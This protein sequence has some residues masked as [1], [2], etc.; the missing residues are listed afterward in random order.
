MPQSERLRVLFCDHLNLARGKYLPGG[1]YADGASTFCRSTFGVQFDKDLLPSPGSMMMEGLPDME[2]RYLGADIRQGW[3]DGEKVVVADL[4]DLEGQPLGTCGRQA[5]K[6][7]IADWQARGLEPMVGIELEATAMQFSDTGRLEPYDNPGGF[8]YGTGPFTDPA[9]VTDAIWH[10]AEEAGF[11]L[12]MITAEY[13]TPQ[14]EF[15]LSF[16]SALKAVDDVFL[17][18]Q[19]AREVALEHGILLT[20]LPKAQADKG[21]TG[22]HVNF[23]FRDDKGLNAI[24]PGRDPGALATGCMAGL[25]RHHRGLAALVAPTV[26][27]YQRLQPASLSGYWNNWAIDHRGV[28]TRIA[29]EGG[30]KARLEHR[31][32]DGTANP[33]TAVAAVLQAARLGVEN[34]YDLPPA[35]TGDC[36][37]RQDATEHTPE[38]LSEAL[39]E[40]AADTALSAAVGQLLVDN[41]IFMKR[42]EIEKTR[43]LAGEALRDWYIHYL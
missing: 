36:F 19:L 25:I 22:M 43:D 4:W 33:Y 5:L 6:R 14:F 40:L 18:R 7:A 29:S 30:A 42:D 17:F 39:D 1:S 3:N 38:N 2:A 28:T 11:R 9:G 31:M 13:D 37:E 8:V 27:S 41:L 26:T 32:A 23:S 16:D 24:G 10:R 12:D 20:F 34:G 21:G 35:E 15:T